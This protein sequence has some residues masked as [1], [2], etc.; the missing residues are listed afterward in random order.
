VNPQQ[1]EVSYVLPDC[2]RDR[3]SALQ[4]AIW[5]L[6]HALNL[7]ERP[8]LDD[9]RQMLRRARRAIA[10]GFAELE[11]L[12]AELKPTPD[13]M[14]EARHSLALALEEQAEDL[15]AT[16]S[17]AEHLTEAIKDELPPRRFLDHLL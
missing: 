15:H 3:S 17:L 5:D 13:E 4:N 16:E 14:A 1:P 2:D 8:G 7:Q 12:S 9:H 11:C 6:R 10:A